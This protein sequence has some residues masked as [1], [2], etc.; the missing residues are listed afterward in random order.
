ML[1]GIGVAL[2]EV[3]R[4]EALLERGGPRLEARIFTGAERAYCRGRRRAAKHFAARLAAKQAALQALGSPAGARWLEA[5]VASDGGT[6]R[7]HL[8]GVAARSAARLRAGRPLLSLSHAGDTAIAT[9][10][11]EADRLAR[12]SG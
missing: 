2:V 6:P 4:L 1:L 7:L 3:S 12:P 11:L 5:E 9:V 10:L 8:T